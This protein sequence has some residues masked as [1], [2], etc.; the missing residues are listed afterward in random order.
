M[1]NSVSDVLLTLQWG[2]VASPDNDIIYS[3]AAK[4]GLKCVVPGLP[5]QNGLIVKAYAATGDVIMLHGFVNKI[6]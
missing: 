1:N 2:G 6:G 4:D 5:L 3:V